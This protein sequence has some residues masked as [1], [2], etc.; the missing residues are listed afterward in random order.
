MSNL[1]NIL[2]LYFHNYINGY[3]YTIFW[4]STIVYS[5][6]F[7][8]YI[9]EYAFKKA[10]ILIMVF[11]LAGMTFSFL[12]LVKLTIS[13]KYLRMI[14]SF[15][16]L[17]QVFIIMRG[18]QTLDLVMFLNVIVSPYY[19]L[20]YL[21][22]LIIFIPA[23]IFF[24]K[25]IFSYFI[26]LSILLFVVFLI[27]TTDMLRTNPNFSEQAMWTLG[28]GGGFILLTWKYHNYKRRL[29]AFLAVLLCLFV[30]TILARR[31]IMLTFSNFL[32]FSLIIVLLS[33]SQSIKSKVYLMTAV[34]IT[35]AIVFFLF[36]HYQEK[37]FGKISD[38][39]TENTRDFVYNAFVNDMSK[40]EWIIGKGF[41]GVYYCPGAE[42]EKNY[43]FMIE[44]GYLQTILK[45]G[46]VSL[47]LFLLIAIPAA[48]LGIVRSKNLL[49][50]ASGIVVMLWLID[51]FP[52]GMPAI[53]IRYILVWI[54]I[55]ICY[56]KVIR[57]FTDIEIRN[58]LIL[59]DK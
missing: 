57:S 59:F 27:F 58:S 29:I 54:C 5:L 38:H 53:N 40:Q 15:Y 10:C 9:S 35:T 22:P 17:W 20:H 47:V 56:S 32:L 52:W 41:T 55:G 7:L 37:L 14:F 1:K 30:S 24:A 43:R 45:G 42:Q 39:L 19:L 26:A 48:Y 34:I 36:L 21:V 6:G 44:S 33:S 11:G 12:K 28:T 8:S 46:I 31:N 49:S 23:N 2:Q 4:V 50:K 13:N 3:A 51:M 18:I 16:I 25:K